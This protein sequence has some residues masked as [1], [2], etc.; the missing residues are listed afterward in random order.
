M[1]EELEASIKSNAYCIRNQMVGQS[2]M[3]GLGGSDY[4]LQRSQIDSLCLTGLREHGEF[5]GVS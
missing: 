4:K 1:A 2:P 5:G 3:V